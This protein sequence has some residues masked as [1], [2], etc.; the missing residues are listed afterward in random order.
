MN[1]DNYI[2]NVLNL[3]SKSFHL[4]QH[5]DDKLIPSIDLIHATLGMATEIAEYVEGYNKVEELGDLWWYVALAVH[6]R[7][8]KIEHT[9]SV[10]EEC[11][12][13]ISYLVDEIKRGL[14]YGKIDFDRYDLY[15]QKVISWCYR[16]AEQI[17]VRIEEVMDKNIEK[18]KKRY[19]D[20]FDNV[21]A[22]NRDVKNETS[23]FPNLEMNNDK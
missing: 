8:L 12:I 1:I 7:Q 19:P 14:F 23:H 20:K 17:K 13:Y 5:N 2:V 9:Q 3:K 10:D 16:S 11:W 21:A 4:T 15:L 6:V 22:I 18:L